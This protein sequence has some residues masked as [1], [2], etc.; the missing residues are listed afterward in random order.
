MMD[1]DTVAANHRERAASV[2]SNGL[3]QQTRMTGTTTATTGLSHHMRAVT[4]E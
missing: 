3:L 1:Q 2:P 4:R